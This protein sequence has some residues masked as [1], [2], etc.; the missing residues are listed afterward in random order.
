MR[1]MI[2]TTITFEKDQYDRLQKESKEQ[3]R[4]IASIVRLA[5]NYYWEGNTEN[6]PKDR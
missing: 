3:D 5:L 4:S 2:R 1:R 6:L